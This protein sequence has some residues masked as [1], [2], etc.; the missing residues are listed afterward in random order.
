M[1]TAP[2]DEAIRRSILPGGEGCW[3]TARVMTSFRLD[4]AG[5]LILGAVGRLAGAGGAVHRG[6]AQRML[7]ALYP[8]AAESAAIDHAWHGRIAMTAD[9][10][11]RVERLGPGA[12]T[13]YGYSGRGIAPGTVFGAAA[14]DWVLTD[15]E[16]AFPVRPV[17]PRDERW[18]GLRARIF[19]AGAVASH[20]SGAR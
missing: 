20:L 4:A 2:L 18:T 16:T 19:A 5:R 6:W 1:A 14:A 11:P 3:D 10:L 9:H 15:D 8:G 17:E 13:I 7:A 12:V